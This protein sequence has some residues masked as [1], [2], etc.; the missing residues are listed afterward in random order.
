LILAMN[1]QAYQQTLDY[2]YS[3]LPMFQRIGAAAYKA[4]LD[5]TIAIDKI[6]H[7]P[8]KKFKAI[9][10][11]GTNGKGSTSHY[12]ASIFQEAGYKTGLYTSPHLIDFRERI[13]INGEMIS[14]EYIVDFVSKFKDDFEKIEPSFFEWTVGLAFNY[15]ADESVDVA[16]I[17]TGLGGRLDSTNIITPELSIITNISYDH[18][19][20]LGNA[21]PL[22]ATEKAGIIKANIPVVIGEAI[23]ETKTVFTEKSSLENAHIYFADENYQVNKKESITQKLTI[24]ILKNKNI[25]Y[26][27]ITSELTGNYQLK[28]IATVC[29]AFDILKENFEKLNEEAFKNGLANVIKNTTLLGRWQTVNNMPLTI[30]DTGHNQAGMEFVLHQLKTYGF[31]NVHFVLGFVNDKE[32]A[33]IFNM[34]P[35]NSTYYFCEPSI[36]RAFKIDTLKNIAKDYFTHNV[37]YYHSVDEALDF[38]ESQCGGDEIIFVGGSTFVVAD[39]LTSINKY[40]K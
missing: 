6:I 20:F 12:L 21:L 27:N 28:N 33:E 19:Q 4:N 5:N 25:I 10:I 11:A 17:E 35:K 15:F 32:V 1:N 38:A 24:D 31:K 2:L 8:H 29:Q 3:R 18:K 39:L 26:E 36:P 40:Q 22:I 13:K 34:L 37:S 16:I 14:K 30:C 23:S 9:H 7:H